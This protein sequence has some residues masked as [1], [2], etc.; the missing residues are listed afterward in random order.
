MNSSKEYAFDVFGIE[1]KK[2]F[3]FL[4]PFDIVAG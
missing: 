3:F 2:R 4:V 1:K